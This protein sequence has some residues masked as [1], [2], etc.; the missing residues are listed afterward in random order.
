M[1]NN[2]RFTGPPHIQQSTGVCEKALRQNIREPP[3]ELMWKDG[4]DPVSQKNVQ[5]KY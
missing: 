3:E 2:L 4:L 5:K 1:D